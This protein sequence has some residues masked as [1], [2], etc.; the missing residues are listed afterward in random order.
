MSVFVLD[1][2]YTLTWCFRDR[3]TPATDAQLQRME[4]RA[5][6]AVVPWVW[7]IEVGNAIGKAVTK[8]KV[9]LPRALEIWDELLLLPIRPVAMGNIPELMQLAVKHNLSLYDTCY[10]QAAIMSKIPLASNDKKL[11]AAAEANGL[12]ILTP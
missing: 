4:S 6:S 8:G 1:A 7:Q 12:T 9:P 11:I 3:A 10:L 2:S 5:D